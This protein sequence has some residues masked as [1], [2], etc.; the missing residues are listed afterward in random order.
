MTADVSQQDASSPGAQLGLWRLLGPALVCWTITAAV[1][2][3]PGTAR[4]VAMCAVAVGAGICFYLI[5]RTWQREQRSVVGSLLGVVLI[6]T[7]R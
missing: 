4:I 5:K 7:L 1:I 6:S 2:H 3:R